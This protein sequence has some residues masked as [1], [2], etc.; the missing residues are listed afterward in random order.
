MRQKLTFVLLL[1]ILAIGALLRF[2]G[3]PLRYGFDIDA[4]RDAILVQY[5]A[6]HNIFPVV[7]A[8]S[9]LGSFNFGPWYYYQLILFQ[10]LIP[11]SYSSWIYISL[12]S[13]VT[14]V[15]M[16]A[17]GTELVSKKFGLLLALLT[18][19]MPGQIIAGTGLS[20]PDLVL[21]FSAL[22]LWL[23]IH[24]LKSK[25]FFWIPLL[26]GLS[27]G[28]GI[29]CHYQML[30]F[31]FLPFFLIFRKSGR[32]KAIFLSFLG[33]F[34]TFIPLL[35]FNLTHHWQTVFGFLDYYV[36]GKNKIYVPNRWLLYLFDFWPT[37]WS[38]VFGLPA[39]AGLFL[40]A[41][42]FLSSLILILKRKVSLAYVL[43]F[44]FFIFCFIMLRFF[45]GERVNYYLIFLHPFL[46]L[47]TGIFLWQILRLCF[48]KIIFGVLLVI[49]VITG[50]RVD[51]AHTYPVSSHVKFANQEQFLEKYYPGKKFSFFACDGQYRDQV[52]A[53][54]FL[55]SNKKLLGEDV[56]IG[57]KDPHCFYPPNTEG[58]KMLSRA[59]AVNLS[60]YSIN[61]LKNYKW[62]LIS[63]KYLYD[64]LLNY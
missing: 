50:I 15:I 55:M 44:A 17:L 33:I 20:N 27:I 34:L 37:F 2:W 64:S 12:I 32:V 22:S 63:P 1:I 59:G 16:W 57:F 43:I 24:T 56:K 54:V 52:Q 41:A 9:A 31:A 45:S 7:G 21:A 5:A 13:L 42:S 40:M 51:L 30:Y 19:L 10:T 29:N 8:V 60:A 62:T 53:M 46:I 4:T 48:G 3:Y 49:I 14:I 39:L 18:A 25:S 36:Y 6:T 61:D 38:F 26:L 28:I 11:F 47:F 23:F 58:D 35:Y